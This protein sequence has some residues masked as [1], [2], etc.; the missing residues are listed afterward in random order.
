[1]RWLIRFSLLMLLLY[2]A[3][4]YYSLYRFN[5]ALVV[6]DTV[7]LN[8]YIDL[9]QLRAHYKVSMKIDQRSGEGGFSRMF[10]DTA[11]AMSAA[12]VDQV[13]T[14]DWVRYQLTGAERDQIGASM[15]DSLDHAFLEG[16][17]TFLVRLGELGEDPLHLLLQRDGLVW[18]LTTL[19]H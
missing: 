5:H 14:V 4:P 18:R 12:T 10:R 3:V 16:P 8:R 7:Q 1:M 17:N 13:V 11:N 19:Y 9:N 15:F 2:M 6:N